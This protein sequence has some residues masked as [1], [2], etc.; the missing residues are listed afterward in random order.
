MSNETLTR[1]CAESD[2]KEG[3]PVRVE[4]EGFPVVAI[5]KVGEEIFIIDDECTHGKASLV[6]DGSVDGNKVICGWH[7]CE[8]DIPSGEPYGFPCTEALHTYTPVIKD[9]GIYFNGEARPP[10]Y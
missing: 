10:A 2:V 8:F 3:A 4:L 9:G 5:F 1:L 6:G 7:N